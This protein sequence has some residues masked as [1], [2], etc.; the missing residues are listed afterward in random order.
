MFTGLEDVIFG[1]G[2]STNF[3]RARFGYCKLMIGTVITCISWPECTADFKAA[4][5][6]EDSAVIPF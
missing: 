3:Q 1:F 6:L 4:R 5:I 2:T